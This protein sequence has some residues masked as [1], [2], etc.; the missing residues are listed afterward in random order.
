M[1]EPRSHVD[2]G[3]QRGEEEAGAVGW[4]DDR[5]ELLGVITPG[6][7]RVGG[8]GAGPPGR[9]LQESLCHHGS[10]APWVPAAVLK[11]RRALLHRLLSYL[12]TV[13]KMKLYGLGKQ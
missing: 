3:G 5:A 1:D 7:C 13:I 10:A 12:R 6:N 4:M 2:S 9:Q 8:E 11:R